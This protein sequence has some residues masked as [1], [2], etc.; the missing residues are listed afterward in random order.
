M[1]QPR[2]NF[3]TGIIRILGAA[4]VAV[5]GLAALPALSQASVNVIKLPNSSGINLRATILLS[6]RLR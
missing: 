6:P 3:M 2:V 1:A 4:I 5:L